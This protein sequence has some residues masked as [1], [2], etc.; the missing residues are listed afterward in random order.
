MYIYAGFDRQAVYPRL[1]SPVPLLFRDRFTE[2]SLELTEQDAAVCT[3]LT[4]ANE[5]DIAK[6]N[7]EFAAEVGP[8]LLHLLQ[9]ARH[10][11]RD[12]AWRDCWAMLVPVRR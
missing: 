7:P 6:V 12:A 10:R 4:A 11:L 8:E 9:G 5:L 1:R 3:E 2:T